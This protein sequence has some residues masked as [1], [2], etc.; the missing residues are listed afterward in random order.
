VE[1]HYDADIIGNVVILPPSLIKPECQY[2][3][4]L[5][6]L[7]MLDDGFWREYESIR[8]FSDKT[9]LLP[10]Q[11]DDAPAVSVSKYIEDPC[12]LNMVQH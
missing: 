2:F 12:D 4:P 9:G 11:F 7:E 10:E 8:Y 5:H 3:L 1:V 6:Q